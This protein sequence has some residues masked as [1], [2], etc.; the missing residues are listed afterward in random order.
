MLIDRYTISKPKLGVV[1]YLLAILVLVGV[2][3]LFFAAQYAF[4]QVMANEIQAFFAALVIEF[5]VIIEALAL[6]RDKKGWAVG[7]LL[8]SL[9]VSG[10]YNYIQAQVAGKAAGI[11][12]PWQ[13][14]TLAVGPLSALTFAS[15]QLGGMLRAHD[16]VVVQWEK[17]RQLWIEAETR[18]L[19]RR[20]DRKDKKER[21]LSESFSTGAETFQKVSN[22]PT[23]WRKLSHEQKVTVSQ[24]TPIQISELTGM[25]P[26]SGAN[27]LKRCEEYFSDLQVDV[28]G[29]DVEDGQGPGA[30][31][32]R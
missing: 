8:V 29:G 19:E 1:A 9:A 13:L 16:Q 28:R 22:F 17:D 30:G 11:D 3:A 27:W 10:T 31:E 23:D 20:K 6:V 5:G 15:L 7:G 26:K 21:K 12:N 14:L 25:T 2:I 24:M 4:R 32:G 18:R